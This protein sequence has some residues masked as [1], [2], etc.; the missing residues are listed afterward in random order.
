MHIEA[1]DDLLSCVKVNKI[2]VCVMVFFICKAH[3][4]YDLNKRPPGMS[5]FGLNSE[6]ARHFFNRYI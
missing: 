3:G 6:R 2:H 4:Y 5:L 1:K